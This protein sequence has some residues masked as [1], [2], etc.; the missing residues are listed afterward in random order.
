[1]LHFLPNGVLCKYMD[2]RIGNLKSQI[3]HL[4]GGM[5]AFEGTQ[6][7]ELK[8]AIAE[9]EQAL[10]KLEKALPNG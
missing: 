3:E 9:T 8:Q 5:I 1:M 2:D 4:K 10:F 6:D 7:T